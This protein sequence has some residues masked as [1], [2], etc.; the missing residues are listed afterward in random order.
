MPNYIF[1]DKKQYDLG[2]C[3]IIDKLLDNYDFWNLK[4]TFENGAL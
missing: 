2:K 3:R 4:F 1:I